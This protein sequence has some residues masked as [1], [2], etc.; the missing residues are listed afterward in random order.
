MV[1]MRA[2]SA[3]AAAGGQYHMKERPFLGIIVYLWLVLYLV[4]L[5]TLS[6]RANR[7]GQ[8]AQGLDNFR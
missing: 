7:G 5:P 3:T 4:R 8:D 6:R 2:P 1:Q